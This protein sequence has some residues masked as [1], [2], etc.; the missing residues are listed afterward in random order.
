LNTAEWNRLKE[1]GSRNKYTR[2]EYEIKGNYIRG[3]VYTRQNQ[4]SG[5]F[6]IDVDSLLMIKD[7]KWCKNR[8]GYI[9]TWKNGKIQYLHHIIA[10]HTPNKMVVIDHINRDVCDNRK[11]NLRPCSRSQNAMNSE[12]VLGLCKHRGVYYDKSKRKF[13]ARL[14]KNGKLVLFKRYH[15]EREAEQSYEY[16]VTQYWG[17]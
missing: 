9:V 4:R 8:G 1:Q 11:V 15:T 13:A 17:A 5:H 6:L 10:N 12:K 16:A 2:N 3:Y 7:Y 14:M